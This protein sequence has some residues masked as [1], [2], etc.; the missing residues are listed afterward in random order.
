MGVNGTHNT[1]EENVGAYNTVCVRAVAEYCSC[2]RIGYGP[3][4][5]GLTRV[6]LS[7]FVPSP[8][9]A[10]VSGQMALV[11]LGFAGRRR[12]V[13]RVLTYPGR[14]DTGLESEVG[15]GVGL[16]IGEAVRRRLEPEASALVG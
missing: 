2:R 16:P 3:W 6:L 10:G 12:L 1:I 14:R 5:R 8:F 7:P 13:S 9:R 15:L 4:Y 11:G